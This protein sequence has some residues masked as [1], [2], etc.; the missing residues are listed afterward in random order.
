[1]NSESFAQKSLSPVAGDC[2]ADSPRGYYT[3]PPYRGNAFGAG[4]EYYRKIPALP[5]ITVGAQAGKI[6]S[7]P[8]M[9]LPRKPHVSGP[10]G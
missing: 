6:L 8:Q 2:I 1:M 7:S 3:Q 4:F 9:L 5:S 10:R